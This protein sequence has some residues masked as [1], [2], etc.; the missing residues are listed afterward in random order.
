MQLLEKEIRVQKD[1][2]FK[3]TYELFKLREKEADLYGDIQSTMAASR[4]LQSHIGKLNQEFQ[5]Q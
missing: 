1:I 5:R 3:N 4:N 2:L